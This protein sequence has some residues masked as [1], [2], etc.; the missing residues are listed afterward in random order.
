MRER[1]TQNFSQH[2][3]FFGRFTWKDL[4][5]LGTP[6]GLLFALVNFTELELAVKLTG[7]L[8]TGLIGV[9]WYGWT[10]YGK[11]VDVHVY[12]LNRWLLRKV[13]S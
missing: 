1:M 2:I 5:R 8:F 9:I 10:P 13:L 11:P 4:A 3:R 12:H 7:L 6:T